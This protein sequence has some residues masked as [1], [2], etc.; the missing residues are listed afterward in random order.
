MPSAF[1]F[2]SISSDCA[3]SSEELQ[4]WEWVE[5]RYVV[6]IMEAKATSAGSRSAVD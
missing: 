2:T 5:G 6:E 1:T 4:A 3:E